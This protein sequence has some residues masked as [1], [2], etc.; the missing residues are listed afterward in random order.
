MPQILLQNIWKILIFFFLQLSEPRFCPKNGK[1][2]KLD[3]LSTY[4]YQK[5]CSD[6]TVGRVNIFKSF[7]LWP[8]SGF[9]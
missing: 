9:L 5:M 4:Q 8:A 1:P 2:T 7:C 3:L 6:L